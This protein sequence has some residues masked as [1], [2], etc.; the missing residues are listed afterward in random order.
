MW[1]W[2]L[3]MSNGGNLHSIIAKAHAYGIHTLFIK[4]SDGSGMWGQFTPAMVSTLHAAG[5][6]VCGWQYV[7]G[8]NPGAEARVGAQAVK[9]GADCLIIDAEAEYEGKYVQA[10]TYITQLRKQIGGRLPLALAGFPYVDYH[11]AFPYTVFLGPGGAQYNV[12][13]MYWQDI[14]VSVDTV[15]SHTYRFNRLFGRPIFPLGQIYS[16]PPPADVVRFRELSLA[17]G[18]TGVSW[19][20]WQEAGGSQW[21]ALAQPLGSLAGF[22]PAQGL[23]TLGRGTVGDLVVWAQEH[24]ITAGYRVPVDGAFGAQ[25]QAAVRSFQAARGLPLSGLITSATWQMLLRFKATVVHWS[26]AKGPR[27]ASAASAAGLTP[28]P[29]SASRPDV[30]N[31]LRGASGRG[32]PR[33]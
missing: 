7:Y 5:L 18:A 28:L 21:R 29:I 23:A 10:Q 13:Q 31:E 3:S 22:S 26:K 11:P 32:R 17:Y 14:G 30:R 19:W 2:V 33:G 16:S 27:S 4:S 8:S 20:D 9:D 15:Y 1:I 12:P 24:L 6:R 25:T